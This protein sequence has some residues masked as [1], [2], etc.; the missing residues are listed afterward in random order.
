MKKTLFVFLAALCLSGSLLAQSAGGDWS[1]SLTGGAGTIL[2]ANKGWDPML[3]SFSYPAIDLRFGHQTSPDRASVAAADYLYPEMGIG[4]SWK[5]LSTL[6]F[7][8]EATLSDITTLYGYFTG[9][10]LRT[11]Y[12][13]LGY[14]LAGGLAYTPT[15]YN[16]VT[17]P[18][19]LSYS[20]HLLMSLSPGLTAKVRPTR[21]LEV[22]LNGRFMHMSSGRLSYPNRGLNVLEAGLRVRWSRKPIP[23]EKPVKEPFKK[24]LFYELF[25]GQGL[26][27][28]R[29]QWYATGE[30]RTWANYLL[31]AAAFYR[32][33]RHLSSG[34]GVDLLLDRE[35]FLLQLREWERTLHPDEDLSEARYSQL[36]GGLSVLHQFHYGNL[37][38][39][40][41]VGYFLYK[42]KGIDEENGRSY[43]RLGIKY[44][45]PQMGNLY[46]AT[47]CRIRNIIYASSMEFIIGI[48]L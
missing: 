17:H 8:G 6:E 22:E 7:V 44:V 14:D 47:D 5:G 35:D 39:W 31:S 28:C 34:I 30:T 40:L 10:F 23:V 16:P 2:N 38:L 20:S 36:S 25:V 13:S 3:R 4:L 9:D 12:F 33:T 24:H 27:S 43:Q 15:V 29:Q 11:R 21:R 26:H 42:H 45:F 18:D 19:L 41:Q 1:I 37:A 46:I 48:R 32:Y